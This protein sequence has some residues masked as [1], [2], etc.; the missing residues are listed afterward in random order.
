M[1][2]GVVGGGVV[3]PV[4]VSGVDGGGLV[5]QAGRW[6]GWL[7]GGGGG[8]LVDVGFSSVV[9]RSVLG[10]RGVVL[11]SEVG[12]LVGGLRELAGG[13]GVGGGLSSV[14]SGVAGGGGGQMVFMFSG[15]GSQ[16]VG[17]GAGLYAAFPAFREG[18]DEVCG[19][20]EGLLPRPLREV[21]FADP[22]A[23]G[24]DPVERG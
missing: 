20:V 5:G 11:A 16:R 22:A 4:V 14:V 1:G 13:G 18:F 10:C 17:M 19:L 24:R 2:V 15:Q 21:L 3:V 7:E 8:R 6:V 12:G 9:S 23:A